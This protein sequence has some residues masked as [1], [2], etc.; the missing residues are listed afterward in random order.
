MVT[1]RVTS[2]VIINE[3]RCCGCGYCVEFCPRECLEITKDKISPKGYA[4]PVLAKPEQCNT[5]GL[6]A[7]MCPHWAVDVYLNTGAPG[8]TGA[9]EKVAGPPR[10]M[11]TPPF[12]NCPGCQHPTVGRII[13]EVLNE[14][15]LG[16]K[17]IAL[18][19]ISCGGSSA[20]SIDVADVLGVYDRPIDIALAMKRAHPEKIVFAIQ[21]NVKFDTTGVDSFIHGLHS[22]EK[23]TVINCY[24]PIYGPWP[25]RWQAKPPINY[26]ITSEGREL[27]AEGYP[28]HTA[29]LAATFKGVAYSARG[30]ITSPDNY[31]LTKSYIRTAFQ[32]QV[33]H[34]GLSFVE[35]LCACGVLSYEPP[36]NCLKW[37]HEKMVSE[38]PLG[39]FKNVDQP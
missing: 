19:G 4:L 1:G 16:D 28:L 30:T 37:I 14:L 39:E 18:D 11:P 31:E 38:F 24:D 3:E 35:V 21:N 36:L 25:N 15:G 29:E 10:L 27:I 34:I 17:F 22:S 2:E 23:I 8:G 9:R 33:D 7:R 13:A 6:C 5:C 32:K 12:I 20:F 26:I